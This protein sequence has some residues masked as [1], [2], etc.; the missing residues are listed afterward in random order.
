MNIISQPTVS[1]IL[2][3]YNQ[4]S[5]IA[6]TLDSI[7]NQTYP[8]FEVI[9]VD[10]GSTDNTAKVIREYEAR[11][12]RI[13][14]Y[15]HSNTGRANATNTAF[16]FATGDLCALID[17]D[18]LMMPNRLERQV[19]YLT[20]NKEI[21]AVSCNCYYINEHGKS[22]GT[23]IYPKLKSIEDCKKA[24]NNGLPMCAITG[25]MIHKTAYLDAGGL[26][27]MFWPCDDIE[28]TARFLDKGYYLIIMDEF[29]M[30]YRVHSNSASMQKLNHVMDVKEFT[31]FSVN[32]RRA[33]IPLISFEQFK[34][35]QEKRPL[36]AKLKTK[37][38]YY[39]MLYYKKAGISYYN[40]NYLQF[41]YQLGVVA[42]LEFGY[43]KSAMK[44]SLFNKR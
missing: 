10:D 3:I 24:A 17:A 23:Q 38:H 12:N 43:L 6:E 19:K 20:E 11:D 40:K 42:L 32:L 25:I 27:N 30:K 35:S 8:N 2:P 29:L 36:L 39:A 33:N 13:K 14:A 7:L 26:D 9:I 16:T 4:E 21:N 5:F 15:F 18:D 22:Q 31:S 34:S 1:I 44:K 37:A 28:F 41:T